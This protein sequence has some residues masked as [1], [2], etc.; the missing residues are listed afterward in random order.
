MKSWQIVVIS[1]LY[2]KMHN[3][4]KIPY[5]YLVNK[6]FKLKNNFCPSFPWTFTQ[7][8]CENTIKQIIYDKTQYVWA[9]NTQAKK[10]LYNCW[11]WW[12]RHLEGLLYTIHDTL[13]T[14]LYILYTLYTIHYTL[15]TKHYTVY[16]LHFLLFLQIGLSR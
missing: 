11:L 3:I 14:I 5:K 4:N 10:I 12:L 2:T 9:T 16:I 13:F 8:E 1:K 15:Y 6:L 7:K